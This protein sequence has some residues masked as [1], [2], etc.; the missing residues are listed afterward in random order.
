MGWDVREF[1]G[2]GRPSYSI[3][4]GLNHVLTSGKFKGMQIKNV[5]ATN[6]GHI[7]WLGKQKSGTDSDHA[8]AVA[9]L[10]ERISSELAAIANGT[11]QFTPLDEM[12]F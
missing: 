10:A 1:Y 7:V 8:Y 5:M 6:P 3:P 11:Y 4:A 2:R 12:P 9:I